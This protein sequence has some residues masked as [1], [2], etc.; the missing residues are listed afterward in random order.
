MRCYVKQ[1]NGV[2]DG[3]SFAVSAEVETGRISYLR[4]NKEQ[5]DI[6]QVSKYLA[7]FVKL[8]SDSKKSE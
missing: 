2:T 1:N 4:Y 3:P 7:E 8:L 5:V 6:Q